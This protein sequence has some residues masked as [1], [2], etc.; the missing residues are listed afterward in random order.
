MKRPPLPP[1]FAIA[2]WAAA[3]AVAAPPDG[4]AEAS[5]RVRSDFAAGLNADQGW[6]G[7]LDEDVTVYADRPIR[8]RFEVER[9]PQ[10]TGPSPFRLQYRRNGGDWIDVEA[11]DF[12]HPQRQ[13]DL[14]FANA[15]VGATPGGWTATQGNAAGMTVA[16]EGGQKVLRALAD[17]EALIGL[18]T[19]PWEA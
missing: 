9:S 14:D 10:S 1:L 12:P 15:A 2:A 17:Q 6:A 7:A 3:G 5:F 11:H 8:V 16:A 18:Y 4:G 19:P 13:L